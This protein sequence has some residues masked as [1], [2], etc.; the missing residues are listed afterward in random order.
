MVSSSYS[1]LFLVLGM[2]IND[3]IAR[4]AEAAAAVKNTPLIPSIVTK[5]GNALTRCKF[6][7]E[8]FINIADNIP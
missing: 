7:N 2:Q 6:T 4:T 5:L 8:T 1:D 3:T